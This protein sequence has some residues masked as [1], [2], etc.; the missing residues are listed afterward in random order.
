MFSFFQ[1]D[2]N[3]SNFKKKMV[4]YDRIALTR[5]SHVP[6]YV[7]FIPETTTCHQRNLDKQSLAITTPS[8]HS[9]G[10]Q[11]WS[12]GGGVWANSRV[13]QCPVVPAGQPDRESLS[14]PTPPFSI[15]CNTLIN[16]LAADQY[17]HKSLHFLFFF[18]S[19]LQ[20][21]EA[22][23]KESEKVND[24]AAWIKCDLPSQPKNK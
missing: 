1:F 20:L 24:Q 17:L 16:N 4:I 10:Q 22:G 18:L 13:S 7:Q 21:A 15:S 11:L 12:V 6:V 5:I 14:P 8:C 9:G 3:A 19:H 2:S 23:E